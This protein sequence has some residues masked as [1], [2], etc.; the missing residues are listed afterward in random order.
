MATATAGSTR[1]MEPGSMADARA[2]L[3][4]H[5][6]LAGE[7]RARVL[8]ALRRAERGMD[9]SELAARVGLHVSTVRFHLRALEA[10][11]LVVRAVE[12]S[13]RP[14]RPRVVHRAAL[15][16][17]ERYAELARALAASLRRARADAARA[18]LGAGRAWGREAALA[19][20]ERPASPGEAVRAL[21]GILDE[22]GFAPEA[23]GGEGSVAVRLRRCPFVEVARADPEVVCSVHLGIMRGA[24][25]AWGSG[26]R[27]TEL[28]PFVEPGLCVARLS[29]AGREVGSGV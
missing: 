21:V 2:E 1:R 15:D 11:G 22:L 8:E 27:A 10:A 9:A 7:S 28:R 5:R 29:L 13:G 18:A 20:G 12:R 3:L 17:G 14:G 23:V 19:T 6:A 25:S 26:V 4:R 16:G 24:L